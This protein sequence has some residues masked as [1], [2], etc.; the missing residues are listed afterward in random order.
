MQE[1]RVQALG[2]KDPLEKGMAI[3]ASILVWKFPWTEE[4]GGLQSMASQ[5]IGHNW[6]T[7]AFRRLMELLCILV[8]VVF[9]RLYVFVK[10]HRT[11]QSKGELYFMKDMTFQNNKWEH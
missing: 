3:H 7:N 9:I 8:A 10:I 2:Q 5:R 6:T 1:T 11:Q 4:P